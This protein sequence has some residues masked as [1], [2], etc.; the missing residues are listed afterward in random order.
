MDFLSV[1]VFE[2]FFQM[3]EEGHSELV[4]PNFCIMIILMINDLK[5]KDVL[6]YYVLKC[7]IVG[8]LFVRV[9]PMKG[10]YLFNKFLYLL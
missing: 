8:S 6:A 3:T 9:L 1:S 10:K 7:Q 5:E 2:D 4:S